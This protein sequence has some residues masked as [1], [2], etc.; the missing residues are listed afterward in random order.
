[1]PKGFL[2]RR[3]LILQNVGDPARITVDQPVIA[4]PDATSFTVTD[5]DGAEG[6]WIIDERPL[7]LEVTFRGSEVKDYAASLVLPV[8]VNGQLSEEQP[9][10]QVDLRASTFATS[11]R[12]VADRDPLDFG[13]VPAWPQTLQA[14][15]AF[16]MFNL[17]D[18]VVRIVRLSIVSDLPPAFSARAEEALPLFI[19]P[20][21][22]K[23]F[24]AS[25]RPRGMYLETAW[26]EVWMEGA[27][28]PYRVELRGWGESLDC[29]D[30]CE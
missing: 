12:L 22:S 30:P 24:L 27:D 20:G 17:G 5:L 1:M 25:Y 6:P 15:K 14:F 11:L 28:E 3:T 13:P 19:F 9:F 7:A 18:D 21:G 2:A 26:L 4:S 8:F 23:S 16:T 10:V 29:E